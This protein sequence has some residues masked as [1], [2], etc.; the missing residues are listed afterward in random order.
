[1]KKIKFITFFTFLLTV[2]LYIKKDLFFTINIYDAYYLISYFYLSLFV[3]IILFLS[4]LYKIN[5]R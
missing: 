2:F 5:K 1:M 4:F 3:L